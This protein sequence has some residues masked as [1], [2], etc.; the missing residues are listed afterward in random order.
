[1]IDA[2]IPSVVTHGS[3]VAV[4]GLVLLGSILPVVPTGPILTAGVAVAGSRHLLLVPL[5]IAVAAVAA[6]LGDVATFAL[7][8]FGGP[9]VVDLVGRRVDTAAVD[10]MT[11]KLADRGGRLLVISRLIPAGRIPVLLAAGVAE[12]PWRTFLPW[13]A[14]GALLWALAYGLLGL[15]GS[16]LFANPYVA[17]GIALGLVLLV[18]LG[19]YSWTRAHR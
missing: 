2:A 7:T 1:V 5:V 10:R 15:A 12:F 16:G 11:H 13:Q 9:R 4:G 3:V 8:R 17:T 19:Q 18:Q 14:L 6:Y